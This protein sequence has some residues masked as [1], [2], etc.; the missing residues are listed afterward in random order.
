VRSRISSSPSRGLAQ[1]VHVGLAAALALGRG[2]VG[3]ELLEA[4]LDLEVAP[5][6]LVAHLGLDLGLDLGQVGVQLLDVDPG[7]QVRGE[8]DDLLE[9]LRRDVSR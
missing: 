2:E 6:L 3:F 7:D 9:A 1:L 4:L 8:V 5:L